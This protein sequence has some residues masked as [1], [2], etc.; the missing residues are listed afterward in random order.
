M[1]NPGTGTAVYETFD[2]LRSVAE[3]VSVIND[4]N[5]GSELIKVEATGIAGEVNVAYNTNIG[6]KI[7]MAGAFTSADVIGSHIGT[8]YLG[9]QVFANPEMVT[10][11]F[12]ATPGMWHRQIQAKGLEL[13]AN[14]KANWVY[15]LPDLPN[16]TDQTAF[17]DGSYNASIV[18]GAPVPTPIVPYPPLAA[19]DSDQGICPSGT[20]V[21]YFDSY[22]NKDVWEPPEGEM[23][24]RIGYVSQASRSWYPIAGLQR[25][26]L[27][28]ADITYSP[29]EAERALLYDM[30][31]VTQEVV[32]PIVKFIGVGIAYYGERTMSRTAKATDRLH[33][34]WTLNIIAKSLEIAGREFP[35]ELNDEVLWRKVSS[36]V[37]SILAP[38]I[39]GGGL[40]MLTILCDKSTNT[41]EVTAQ[42]QCICKIFMKFTDAVEVMRFQLIT[43]ASAA[44][45]SEVG[46]VG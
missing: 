14:V 2:S 23:L 29:T 19:V 11:N 38:V 43:S 37:R 41:P 34:R 6:Q 9:L 21:K 7:G 42:K 17:V 8:S 12:L 5:T 4:V 30:N 10:V 39:S 33:I 16:P 18:G 22:A 36:R 24:N 13:G 25:G 46:Q 26:M 44:S 40:E 15:S 20:W 35:F 27:D 32:N 3:I 45:F 1:F 31:G 28:V